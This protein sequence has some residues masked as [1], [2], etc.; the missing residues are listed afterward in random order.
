MN[1][2]VTSIK[3]LITT[4][5]T[6][7]KKSLECYAK[8][9]GILIKMQQMDYD[10]FIEHLRK[11]DI[12]Y[13]KAQIYLLIKLSKLFDKYPI[14]KKFTVSLDFISKHFKVIKHLCEKNDW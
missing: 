1:Q 9:G 10:N 13:S 8:I 6:Y 11:N 12:L 2:C 4:Y 7:F 3:M 5:K 14:V